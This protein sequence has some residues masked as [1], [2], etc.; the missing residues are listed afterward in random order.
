[1]QTL[2]GHL[3]RYFCDERGATAIEYGMILALMTLAIIAAITSVGEATKDTF[4]A[5][6]EG[7]L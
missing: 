2:K 3:D 1:M 6:G 4:E 7:W 5:A